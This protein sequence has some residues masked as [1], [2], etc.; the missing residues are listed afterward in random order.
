MGFT[1]GT[2]Q[3]LNLSYGLLFISRIDDL[4]SLHPCIAGTALQWGAQATAATRCRANSPGMF[5]FAPSQDCC[6]NE[7]FMGAMHSYVLQVFTVF[8]PFLEL[9]GKAS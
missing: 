8:E 5:P 4:V 7:Q 6:Y 9:L 1:D 2:L 3:G